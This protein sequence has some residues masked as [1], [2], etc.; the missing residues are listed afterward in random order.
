MKPAPFRY[1]RVDAVEAALAA[2]A[3]N[4]DD[5]KVL[6]GGQSLVP[7]L[8]RRLVHPAVLIDIGKIS[9][10]RRITVL[11]DSVSVGAMVSARSAERSTEIA[12]HVPLL[13]VTLPLIG[14]AAI[15]NR[16][17]VGGSISHAD[18]A[19]EIP[20][21]VAALDAVVVAT[22]AARGDRLIRAED[23]FRGF[24][25]TA[26]DPDELVTEIRLP[27]V[28]S[29][30]G[31]AIEEVSRRQGGQ[32]IVGAAVSVRMNGG[33]VRDPRIALLGVD[34]TPVRARDA[35][36][37]LNGAEPSAGALREAVASTVSAIAP[38]SDI[39]GVQ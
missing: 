9:E 11:P 16:G 21:V 22:S 26:L 14:P 2:L 3:E 10:L 36:E 25:K 20:A 34:T 13:A 19:G 35:E 15:R 17:T 24:C 5:A 28:S 8:A 30:T 12:A 1:Q 38:P 7:L 31:A 29:Q 39:H 27:K 33:A 4:G 6:A 23:F 18:P 37:A 32:A